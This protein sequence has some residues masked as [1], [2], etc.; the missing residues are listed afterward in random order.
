MTLPH[1]APSWNTLYIGHRSHGT[2]S[3][4]DP[5]ISDTLDVGHP[6]Y[7]T[8]SIWDTLHMEHPY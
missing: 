8:P 2:S 5:S 4:W 1:G 3:T 6:P 7:G